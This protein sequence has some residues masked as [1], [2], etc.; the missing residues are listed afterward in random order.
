MPILDRRSFLL[1]SAA[2]A[3]AGS[4][5]SAASSVGAAYAAMYGPVTDRFFVPGAPSLRSTGR[6]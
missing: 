3:A 4:P 6:S 1:G 5:P 2:A